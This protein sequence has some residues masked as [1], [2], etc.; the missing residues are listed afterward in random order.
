MSFLPQLQKGFGS[1]TKPDDVPTYTPFENQQYGPAFDGSPVIIG[2]LLQDSIQTIPYS[3][4]NSREDFWKTGLANQYQNLLMSPSQVDITK[5]ENWQTDPFANPNGL[6]NEYFQNPYFSLANNRALARND[7]FQG[8]M[9]LKWNPVKPLTLT[10]RVGLTTK[11]LSGKGTS[12]KFIYSDYTKSISESSKRTLQARLA[13]T[14]V[15]RHSLLTISLL[16]T[17][18]TSAK[19]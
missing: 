12:D 9:E 3:A 16:N 1:G 4:Q 15:L 8:N 7:Y 2:K 5:Y 18:R 14:V 10:A 6:Y 19:I 11:N 17:R 13:I